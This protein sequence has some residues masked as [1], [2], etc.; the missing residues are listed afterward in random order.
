VHLHGAHV[1]SW[2]DGHPQSWYTDYFNVGG[3]E[4]RDGGD[5]F[6]STGIKTR[7]NGD[8]EIVSQGFIVYRNDQAACTLFYHDHAIGITRLNVYAGLAG[9]YIIED[10]TKKAT[11]KSAG[12]DELLISDRDVPLA[13]MDKVFSLVEDKAVLHYPTGGSDGDGGVLPPNSI[14][15]EMFGY[16]MTVNGA[17]YPYFEVEYDGHYL[18]R[19]LNACDSRYL[20]L[21]F[22]IQDENGERLPFTVVGN[23]QG[24]LADIVEV[25]EILLG[26]AERYEI[27][28]SFSSV[29]GKTLILRNSEITLLGPV[30]EGEDDQFMQFKVS[31]N[32]ADV[33]PA[34]LPD[35]W[36]FTYDDLFQDL[37]EMTT[38]GALNTNVLSDFVNKR[39][40]WITERTQILASAYTASGGRPL[41]MLA[42]R[43]KPFGQYYDEAITEVLLKDKP[44][45]WE[46]LNLSNDAHAIHLHQV[47]F[48]IV[49]RRDIGLSYHTF[50]YPNGMYRQYA[51][52]ADPPEPFEAGPKD[53]FITYPGTVTRISV[54]FDI[55]GRYVWHC[56][57]KKLSSNEYDIHSFL[58][59]Q[60]SP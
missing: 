31:G 6:S 37:I 36:D 43:F 39:E 58:I 21:Y 40:L 16:T 35:P 46:F 44:M 34:V 42:A 15:P 8:E 4:F 28:V 18:F 14:L 51:K 52:D 3:E 11:F 29:A 48:R 19:L 22:E 5:R 13:F 17:I 1:E 30:V 47:R 2:Y 12:L 49:D 20:R 24:L 25:D 57:S 54:V 50:Q 60:F 7:I 45:V 23:D 10:A 9:L 26:P 27:V 53:T 33:A 41:P 38:P 56:V 59:D 55:E 32:D